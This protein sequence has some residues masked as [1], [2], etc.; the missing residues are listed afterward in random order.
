MVLDGNGVRLA[1]KKFPANSGGYH[2]LLTW[3]AGFGAISHIR[4]ESTGSYAAGLSRHLIDV[5]E[6]NSPHQYTKVQKR[7]D[8]AIDAEAA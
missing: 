5:I 1:D 2:Q 3:I 6:V 8:D 4:I 7:K